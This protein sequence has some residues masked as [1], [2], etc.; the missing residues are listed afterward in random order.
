MKALNAIVLVIAMVTCVSS[1]GEARSYS[2]I[3]YAG[4]RHMG[5]HG[6]SYIAWGGSSHRGGHYRN[7]RTG[8]QHGC[9]RC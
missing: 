8:N 2:R 7:Y 1:A 6:G 9:H 4:L 3:R 5:S